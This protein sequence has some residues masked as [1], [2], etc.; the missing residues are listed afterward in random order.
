MQEI[1]DVAELELEKTYGKEIAKTITDYLESEK[2]HS[3][4]F[5]DNQ[6][7]YARTSM[8][9]NKDEWNPKTNKVVSKFDF[10]VNHSIC[11]GFISGV[12]NKDSRVIINTLSNCLVPSKGQFIDFISGDNGPWKSVTEHLYVL[13][14]S[15]NAN[16][17]YATICLD[18]GPVPASTYV[19]YLI[20]TRLASCWSADIP[21]AALVSQGLSYHS[22]LILT[23][24]MQLYD[25][26]N[27]HHDKIDNVFR[28]PS[29]NI[30][31][32]DALKKCKF[33]QFN[34]QN[35]APFHTGDDRWRHNKEY[36]SPKR[37]MDNDP[38]KQKTFA[39]GGTAEISCNHIWDKT[40]K[41]PFTT[42]H[43]N[44]Q[45]LFDIARG[46]VKLTKKDCSRIEQTLYDEKEQLVI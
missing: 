19:N 21:W 29:I 43:E 34:D 33:F 20:A 45:K 39:E 42:T 9:G 6:N 28:N 1:K 46:K 15:E 13:R 16:C 3:R 23:S 4:E 41:N 30:F 2:K 8:L 36:I 32:E 11:H 27:P 5:M 17:P 38:E 10:R 26:T 7:G 40:G 24:Y 37:I 44:F 25:P 14:D 22:A 35:E 12:L 31:S 18:P